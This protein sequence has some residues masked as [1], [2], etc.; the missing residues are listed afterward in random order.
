MVAVVDTVVITVEATK[1]V[2]VMD[3]VVELAEWR[4]K[5]VGG[6][7]GREGAAGAKDGGGGGG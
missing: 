5:V 1:V 3:W 7:G 2:V 4:V 6:G